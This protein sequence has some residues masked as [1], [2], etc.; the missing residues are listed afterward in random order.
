MV[1][2]RLM[3]AATEKRSPKKKYVPIK[4]NIGCKVTK[5]TEL[6]TD[7]IFSDSNQRMK[8]KARNSP[9]KAASIQFFF[10]TLLISSLYFMI[11]TGNMIATAKNIR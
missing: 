4:A 7:V 8:C 10:D 2:K 5:T 6:A 9:E 1:M 11:I 3:V